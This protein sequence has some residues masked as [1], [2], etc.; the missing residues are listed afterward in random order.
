MAAHVKASSVRGEHFFWSDE[1][2]SE[3]GRILGDVSRQAWV[4]VFG[5]R[6]EHLRHQGD[7][8]SAKVQGLLHIVHRLLYDH[9]QHVGGVLGQ[10]PLEADGYEVVDGHSDDDKASKKG[11]TNTYGKTLE[12]LFPLEDAFKKNT[13]KQLLVDMDVRHF[14]PRLI[15]SDIL[16]ILDTLF[17]VFFP[18]QGISDDSHILC[19]FHRNRGKKIDMNF[20]GW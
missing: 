2:G 16:G 5:N 12:R 20:S 4:F 17:H 19:K 10:K 3:I 7:F 6:G 9:L 11:S 18:C 13:L 14:I 8:L 1:E 15:I